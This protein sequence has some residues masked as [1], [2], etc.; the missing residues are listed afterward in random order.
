MNATPPQNNNRDFFRVVQ[1]SAALGIGSMAAFLYSL[2][3]VHPNVRLELGWDTLAAFLVAGIFSWM[4]C[5]MLAKAGTAETPGMDS[6]E[7]V[8]Q[9]KSLKRWMVVFLLV[10]SLG[11]IAAFTYSLKDVSAQGRRDVATGTAIACGVLGAGAWLIRR[12]VQFFEEDS[13]A[14]ADRSREEEEE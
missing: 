7:R 11:T 2:K 13:A 5:G 3:Q 10:C 6:G 4:F 9:G 14:Q 12:A 8:R 1:F